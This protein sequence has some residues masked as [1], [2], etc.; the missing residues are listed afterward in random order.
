MRRGRSPLRCAVV[1]R[2]HG[3]RPCLRREHGREGH[4]GAQ[5]PPRR[6]QV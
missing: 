6:R 5:R 4:P 3:R 1:K 2:M